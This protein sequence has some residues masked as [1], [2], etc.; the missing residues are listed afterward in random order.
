MDTV[1]SISDMMFKVIDGIAKEAVRLA[2]ETAEEKFNEKKSELLARL[3]I[4]NERYFG[5]PPKFEVEPSKIGE[6]LQKFL[7]TG[8]NV[9][10][11][12]MAHAMYLWEIHEPSYK[13]D[14]AKKVLEPAILEAVVNDLGGAAEAINTVKSRVR[15][16]TADGEVNPFDNRGRQG[17]AAGEDVPT[18]SGLSGINPRDGTVE[19][20]KLFEAGYSGDVEFERGIDRWKLDTENPWIK[21]A[22]DVLKMPMAAGASGT[23]RDFMQVARILGL[24]AGEP[25]LEYGVACLG[26]LAGMGAH[27][28]HEVLTVVRAAG[29]TY[30]DGDYRSVYPAKFESSGAFAALKA[31]WPQFLG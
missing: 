21:Q 25:L 11:H 31:K 20:E 13:A 30:T 2:G 4:T 24:G 10:H 27:S 14:D 12:L 19:P 26:T 23:A 9:E 6:E 29:G 5:R 7:T 15:G 3:V 16:Q 22:V 18:V 17:P 1:K 8:G 28:F